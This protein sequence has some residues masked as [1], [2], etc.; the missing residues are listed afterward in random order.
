MKKRTKIIA[1]LGPASSDTEIIARLIKAGANVFRLNFSHGTHEMHKK[2]IEAVR[3]AAKECCAHVG[4]LGDLCGPKI[5]VG[6]FPSG[7]VTLKRGQSF[8][9]YEKPDMPGTSEGVGTSYPYLV[10]DISVD[11][12]VLLDDGNISLR[13]VEKG[14]GF[15]RFTVCDGGLLK[16]K[17]GMNMPG[18]KLSIETIT[19][20][21]KRDLEFMMAEGID[22]VALSFVRNAQDI[23]SLRSMMNSSPM[24]VIAKIE[25]PEALIDLERILD[26]TDGV[27]I[28][29]GDL[30][31]EVAIE[32]VPAIQNHIL[33][34]CTNR[35]IPVITA[36]QMLESMMANS[37]PTRAETTD[38]YNAIV[39]GSDAV[40]LS[41]ETAAGDFPVE[42]VAMMSA[43]AIEAEKA[44]A[45]S[46]KYS[47]ILPEVRR[48]IEEITAQAACEAAVNVGAKAIVP[49]TYSGNT[50]HHI[51]KYHP[52]VPIIALTPSADACRRLSLCWGVEPILVQ[53]L[54]NTD[55][56][57]SLAEKTLKDLRQAES[58]D[59]L[60]IV[61]GLPLGIKGNTNLLKLH[62]VG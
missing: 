33:A 30:G 26:A 59:S 8:N 60:I 7:P 12:K 24:K 57:I 20:K 39:E 17:K 54:R 25:K 50:A 56:M 28:A 13:A 6:T 34:R 16:D 38:V 1:T 47:S 2:L 32:R 19:E 43:I 10:K 27:M 44:A 49:F 4:I 35:G 51:S 11:D 18:I 15:V 48:E 22:F 42:S 55:E 61:A 5:R 23:I 53:D 41:G 31:V 58:G 36:T 29:R 40:M 45:A 21:D 14:P 62:R 9:L 37:R 52:P 3:C 46:M